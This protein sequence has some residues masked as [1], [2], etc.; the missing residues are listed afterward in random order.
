[1]WQPAG[2][3]R[4]AFGN[5]YVAEVQN[6]VIRRITP[7]G[8]ISTVAGTGTCG[9]SADGGMAT[10]AKLQYPLDVAVDDSGNLYIAETGNGRVRMVATNGTI[11]TFA[12]GGATFGD[13]GPAI[14]A[15]LNNPSGVAVDDAG[16]VYIAD[17]D[18]MRVRRV[19]AGTIT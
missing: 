3:A 1:M 2:T 19:T 6:C 18:N 13:N 8:T 15:Q 12:G 9:T 7:A 16:S 14:D 10:N 5:L 17:R 11:T 4:D